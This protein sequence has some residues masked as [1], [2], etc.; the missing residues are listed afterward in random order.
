MI[1]GQGFS[2]Q[3]R[4]DLSILSKTLKLYFYNLSNGDVNATLEWTLGN[5]RLRWL[6]AEDSWEI[7]LYVNHGTG[8]NW[9]GVWV[10]CPEVTAV[11]KE[12]LYL[13]SPVE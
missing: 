1:L 7:H 11:K 12:I 8:L 3:T 4:V 9:S 2:N 13:G 5:N 10:S 6:T